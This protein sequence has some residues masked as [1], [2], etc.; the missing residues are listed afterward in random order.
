MLRITPESLT[1]GY[2]FYFFLHD[3]QLAKMS[4]TETVE[5]VST[6]VMNKYNLLL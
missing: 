3:N 4:V 6:N 2:F 5:L 1:V